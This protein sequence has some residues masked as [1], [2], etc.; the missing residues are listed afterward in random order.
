[1]T[2]TVPVLLKWSYVIVVVSLVFPFGLAGSSWVALARGGGLAGS[3]PVLGSLFLLAIGIYRIATVWKSPTALVSYP[4]EGLA[5]VLRSTGVA[6]L[7][8]GAAAAVLNLAAGPLM[9]MLLTSRTESGAEF[10]VAGL[11][12]SMLGSVGAFG[13]VAFELARIIGFERHV[14]TAFSET[15]F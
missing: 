4:T 6:A 12:V 5:S 15:Q 11:F 7:Y 1:M 8:F 3:I 9:R 2:P 13:L 10:F 14:E